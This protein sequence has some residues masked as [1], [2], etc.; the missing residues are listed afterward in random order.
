MHLEDNNQRTNLQQFTGNEDTP[1]SVALQGLLAHEEPG[2]RA[3]AAAPRPSRAG[4]WQHDQTAA[5]HMLTGVCKVMAR[6][7]EPLWCIESILQVWDHDLA[8][9]L[10]C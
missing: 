7:L 10:T 8:G 3:S 4:C 9:C 1:R 2:C 5:C 6:G